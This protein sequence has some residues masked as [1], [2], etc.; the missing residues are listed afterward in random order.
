V[1]RPAITAP[2]PTRRPRTG[3]WRDTL[4]RNRTQ[5]AIV[6]TDTL[7]VTAHEYRNLAANPNV[8]IRHA[9][10]HGPGMVKVVVRY[11]D[12]AAPRRREPLLRFSIA[13]EA[14]RAA[15][16]VGKVTAGITG[17]LTG[18]AA[19][20]WTVWAVWGEQISHALLLAAGAAVTA[21][22]IAGLMWMLSAKAGICPGLHCPGCPHR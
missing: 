9:R 13:P 3:R 1:T 11:P 7:T 21:A 17:S 2:T 5:V 15:A 6:R 12:R 22:V 19:L 14:L 18:L 8:D 16:T 4:R 10:P 20:G